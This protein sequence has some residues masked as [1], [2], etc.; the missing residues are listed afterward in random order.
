LPEPAAN[1]LAEPNV[2]LLD[3]AAWKLDEGGWQPEAEVLRLDNLVRAALGQ[4]PRNGDIAQPWVEPPRP[5]THH[6]TL[7][8]TLRVAHATGPLRLAL[9][10]AARASIRLDGAA[11]PAM[12][13]GHF[14]D[15]DL[16]TLALPAL[17]AGEH[18]L[19]IT[20]PCGGGSG[21]EACYLLGDFGVRV[22]GAR[23][24]LTAPVRSLHWGDWTAQGL[25]FYGGNVTYRCRLDAPGGTLAL[26]IPRFRAPL[27]GIE[28]DGSR[29]GR[30][31][32]SPWRLELGSPAA[33]GHALAITAFGSRCNLLGQ[34]HNVHHRGETSTY[35]WWGPQSWRTQG[36]E[37][38]D[39]YQLRTCGVLVAPQIEAG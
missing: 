17:T 19:E 24:W 25:P 8:F 32:R 15:P 7:A 30:I 37:W 23:T 38:A 36:N 22:G 18:R 5:D 12:M 20:W 16:A 1:S 29:V 4:G 28:L 9:E 39:E 26:R 33:G 27:L 11:L 34:V 31:W 2:L 14:I 13:D 35:R 21:L 3:R 6:V 10:D